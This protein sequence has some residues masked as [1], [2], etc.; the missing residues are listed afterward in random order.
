MKKTTAF[1]IISLLALSSCQTPYER[2]T[3]TPVPYTALPGW[4]SDKMKEALPAL[5]RSCSVIQ[6]KDGST[7][8]LTGPDGS[9]A[10]RDWSPFCRKITHSTPIDS[11]SLRELIEENLTPYQVSAGRETVGTFT[12]YYE[13]IL[14]GS[15]H[16]K[17]RYQTPLYRM[18]GGRISSKI[19][20]SQIVAGALKNKN[21]EI[22]WVDDPVDAFFLQIQGSGK[23]HLDNGQTLRLGYAGQNGYPY[24]AIGKALVDQGHLQQ[25]Q[26]SMQ[27]IRHWL[28]SHPKQAE[29]IMS[30]NQSYVFFRVVN[31]EGPIGSQG[32]PLTPGRSLAVDRDHVSLGTPIWLD[33]THP[34]AGSPKIQRLVVAQDT[35]GA[36]KGIVRGD[37]FWGSGAE[38]A[39]LAGHMNSKG[40]YYILLPR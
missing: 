4:R 26:V 39:E 19:P 30:L 32:V 23:V 10:A 21:L 5:K 17:G 9:G 15:R 8:M 11:A 40:E 31:G 27:S 2:E 28:K 36:I 1:G 7:E 25:G 12:G 14:N 20:R 22:V 18:P 35:G 29:S 24:Y 16:R 37:L 6:K 34:F 33:V 38:A 13:P 3:L